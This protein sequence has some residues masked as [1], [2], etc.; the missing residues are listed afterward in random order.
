[1]P[2]AIG[3]RLF[4]GIARHTERFRSLYRGRVAVEREF[5]R[6]KGEFG[7]APLRVRQLKRVQLHADLVMLAR[8]SLALSR[9]REAEKL[10]A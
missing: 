1:L 4:P 8:L 3:G 6:L 7:F 2:V 10:A 5:A 9:I